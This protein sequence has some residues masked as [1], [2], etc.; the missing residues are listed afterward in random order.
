MVYNPNIPAAGDA[1]SASQGQI[2]TNFSD[3]NT[4]FSVNHEAFDAVSNNGK[5]KSVV[6]TVQT[7][8]TVAAT[9]AAMFTK[10]G[11]YNTNPQVFLRQGATNTI[12]NAT[13]SSLGTTGWAY[14]PNGLLI[15]WGESQPS[16][17]A[18]Y[19]FSYPT[20]ASIPVFTTIY[21]V[22]ITP[23]CTGGTSFFA[24]L[25]QSTIAITGFKY[26]INTVQPNPRIYYLAIGV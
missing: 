16:G 10:A 14:L 19:L 18:P 6:M 21:R 13:E 7:N 11:T 2:Q 3:A 26:T 15:K 23:A 20:A 9:D 22:L 25:D 1:L 8:P 5:H 24:T 4:Y 17:V 12:F